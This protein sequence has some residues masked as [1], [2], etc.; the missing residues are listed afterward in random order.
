MENKMSKM[1]KIEA[2]IEK[3]LDESMKP[4]NWPSRISLS[5]FKYIGSLVQQAIE[6]EG[7]RKLTAKRLATAASEDSGEDVDVK[8]AKQWLAWYKSLIE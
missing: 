4:K 1:S 8:V 6:D 3:K 5:A 7:E 2:L